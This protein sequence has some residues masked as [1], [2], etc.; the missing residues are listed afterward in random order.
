MGTMELVS[1]AKINLFLYVTGKR[2]DGYHDLITLMCAI[3][4]FDT[5]SL[6][7]ATDRITITCTDPKIPTDQ[8]NLAY[9]AADRFFKLLNIR[10]GVDIGIDKRIPVA[11]GLGGGSSN[12]ATVLRGLN[13]HFD[14]PLS[15]NELRTLGLSIGAD[16]P[17]FIHP[18]PALA[19]GVGELLEPYSNIDPHP[20][21]LIFPGF[22]VSTASVYNNLNLGLTNCKK[23]I[24]CSVLKHQRFDAEHHLHND[25][26]AVTASRYPAILSAKEALLRNGAIGAL[27]SGSGPTVFGIFP[28]PDTAT[29][30]SHYLSKNQHW[31]VIATD[32]WMDGELDFRTFTARI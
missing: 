18:E 27:M 25:L 31:Q 12:A 10:E 29:K 4:L 8:T 14:S 16:V 15:D 11:A 9:M 6:T 3:R 28:D 2:T 23:T 30:A 19:R 26:E 20:I 7:F 1:P 32:I 17:F 21:V 13:R 24:T 22:G 5:I